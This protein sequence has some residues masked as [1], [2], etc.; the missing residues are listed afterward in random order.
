MS[1]YYNSKHK[2][3]I[4]CF[5]VVH[6]SLLSGR[7]NLSVLGLYSQSVIRRPPAIFIDTPEDANVS[8]SAGDF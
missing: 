5:F 7:I 2:H 8:E 6:L 4:L 1:S 3:W